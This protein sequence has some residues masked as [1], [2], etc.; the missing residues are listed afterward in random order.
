MEEKEEKEEEGWLD[1]V[2]GYVVCG[3][4][5]GSGGL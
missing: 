5:I 3:V 1:I 4:E 2:V